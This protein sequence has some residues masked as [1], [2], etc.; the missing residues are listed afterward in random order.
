MDIRKWR[1]QKAEEQLEELSLG[2]YGRV[3]VLWR[4][5]EQRIAERQKRKS[6]YQRL[7]QGEYER[8]RREAKQA[9]REEMKR[10][11]PT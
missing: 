4:M 10:C 2:Q 8:L 1:A 3:G 9:L 11:S 7:V 6:K 5:A